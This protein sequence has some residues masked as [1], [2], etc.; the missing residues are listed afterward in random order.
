VI[1]DIYTHYGWLFMCPVYVGRA[2]SDGPHMNVRWEWLEWWFN[3]N[4]WLF[5]MSVPIMEMIDPDYEPMFPI[6]LT[7]A[8]PRN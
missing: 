5:S 1:P 8:I 6:R 2:D 3:V 4:M 7:G